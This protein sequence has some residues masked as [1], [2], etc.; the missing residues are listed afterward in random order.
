MRHTCQYW[1]LDDEGKDVPCGK[2]AVAHIAWTDDG[3]CTYWYC[4]LH[5]DERLDV[6]RDAGRTDVLRLNGVL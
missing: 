3:E 2:P 4:A 5:Y 6:I 1:V